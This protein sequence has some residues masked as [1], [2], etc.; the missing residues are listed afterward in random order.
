MIL[1]YVL[2]FGSF[3]GVLAIGSYAIYKAYTAS[4]VLGK[5]GNNI[6]LSF[7][8]LVPIVFILT[9]IVSMKTYSK[10]NSYLYTITSITLPFLLY[11]FIG[12]I[13]L[14]I[15]FVFVPLNYKTFYSILTYGFLFI[16]FGL[17]MY[18]L[19][20]AHRFV[21]RNIV[22]P[23]ENRLAQYWS[24]K[25]IALVA[26]THIGIVH[27]KN[28]MQKTVDFVMS[29]KPDMV[30]IAGDL[31]DG[32]KFPQDEYLS[33]L[34]DLVAPMG[35]Y[36]APGNHEVYAGN[37][38][39]LYTLTDTTT[40]GL[41]DSKI[42]INNTDIVGLNYDAGETPASLKIR[43]DKSG[44]NP[45]N[46]SILII[47]EPKNNYFVQDIGGDLIVSGHTH[48]GQFWPFSYFI[49]KKYGSYTSGL[50]MRNNK[51]SITTTGIGTWGPPVRIDQNP[52]IIIIS[53]E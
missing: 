4:N 26:D 28:F 44:F 20:N 37:L 1:R 32:P 39:D 35:V 36:Y 24:G 7:L 17:T 48:G 2:F 34:K 31:V 19:Y 45:Q 23:K 38:K 40:T 5:I 49:K 6:L 16:S 43:L 52:E 51:A 13:I 21:V 47:H 46:P 9:T 3:F 25:R 42:T 53:F 50:N 11:L 14:T 30:L 22:I 33:P 12:A 10:I 8:V 29:Q 15:I 27:K 18:G 41:R